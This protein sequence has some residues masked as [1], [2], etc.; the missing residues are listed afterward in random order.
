MNVDTTRFGL[1]EADDSS[2]VRMPRGPLGFDDLTD[3]VLVQ[4]RPDTCFK[5]LQSMD[6]PSLA[7]AVV[8]PEDFFDN[9]DIEIC[10]ADAERL[11]LA[12]GEDALVL[13]IVTATEEGATVNLA[14]PVVI[15]SKERVG[16]QIVLQDHQYAVKYPLVSKA[17][18]ASEKTLLAE[19]A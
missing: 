5:W 11:H 10:E 13:A 16:M 7:F 2:I 19:A 14:A 6:E 8:D 1:V 4:H 17:A 3:Y 12:E 9:Y 18:E 15:N